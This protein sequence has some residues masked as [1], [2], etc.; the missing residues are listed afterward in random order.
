MTLQVQA[1]YDTAQ[2]RVE[3]AFTQFP[4]ENAA[5]YGGWLR[6]TY[7]YVVFTTRILALTGAKL[8]TTYNKLSDRFIRHA[9]EERGHEKLLEHD[10]RALGNC[11]QD[12]P[13][14]VEAQSFL[15]AVYY[16][17]HERNPVGV[18]GYVLLLEG[19]AVR[20]GERLRERLERCYGRHATQF[21]RV[22]SKD[23]VSHI[24]R[25]FEALSVLSVADLES[26]ATAIALQA[27]LYLKMLDGIRATTAADSTLAL[28]AV[29]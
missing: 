19:A 13:P 18:L 6:Q 14:S 21:V 3:A 12:V 22:H 2:D 29:G 1:A 15:H 8:P 24:A 11:S 16:W 17:L 28:R 20:N 4:W 23:D 7:H 25:A 27:E 26:V 5:A 9:G 10:M